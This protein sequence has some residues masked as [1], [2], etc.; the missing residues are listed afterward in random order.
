MALAI[1]RMAI[2]SD[3]AGWTI[4]VSLARHPHWAGIGG[5]ERGGVATARYR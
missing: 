5:T 2:T 1:T 4:M 3:S